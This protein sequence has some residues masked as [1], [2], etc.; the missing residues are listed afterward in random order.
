MVVHPAGAHHELHHS[1]GVQLRRPNLQALSSSAAQ[2]VEALV[3]VV[4]AGQDHVDARVVELVPHRDSGGEVAVLASRPDRVVPIRRDALRRIRGQGARDPALGPGPLITGVVRAA[5]D[6]V[7]R[8][9]QPV[10]LPEGV[11][12]LV[13][14]VGHIT[15]VLVVVGALGGQVVMVARHRV[16]LGLDGTECLVVGAQQSGHAAVAVLDVTGGQERIRVRRRDD[17]TDG[18]LPTAGLGA[19]T[20]VE[21]RRRRIAGDVA[22]DDNHRVPT[23]VG[24]C[25]W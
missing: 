3:Q 23:L 19:F 6:R 1:V 7:D 13:L 20:V 15:E 4:V 12:P 16:G 5:V 22:D 10:A 17:L 8:Q 18:L 25:R 21:V 14:L 11:G 9:D 2:R 24:S